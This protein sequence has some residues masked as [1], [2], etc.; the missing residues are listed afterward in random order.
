LIVDVELLEIKRRGNH[1][2]T[3]LTKTGK[4]LCLGL[5]YRKETLMILRDKEEFICPICQETVILKLGDHRIF[6]FAHKQDSNCREFYERETYEHLEGKRQIFQWLTQQNIPCV[7]EYYDRTIQQRPDIMFKYKGQRFALEFQCSSLPDNVFRK[8][9]STYLENGY[10]P[11]WVMSSRHL[12]Q[13]RNDLISLSDFHYSFLRSS[14]NGKLYIPAYCPKKQL[15][16]LVESITPFSIKN[17]FAHLSGLSIQTAELTTILEPK[18]DHCVSQESWIRE[19]EKYIF[20]W[21]LHPKT[22]YRPFLQEVYN[23]GLN[24]FLLPPE[25]G[26]PV[27]HSVLIQTPPFI[28]QTYLFIDVLA[29]K[30]PRELISLRDINSSY[31]KRVNRKQIIL[32]DL[33]QIHNLNPIYAM[34]EYLQVLEKL[35]YLRK[36]GDMIFEVQKKILIPRS[37]REREEAKG[38]FL[39]QNKNI[40]FN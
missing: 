18:N 4:M 1:L 10:T 14:S 3:A 32:R 13:R 6:H 23:Q 39:D 22:E 34:I 29:N 5:N 26:L 24:T 17:S 2:L 11:L 30:N 12:H 28:W 36:K 16:Q 38:I 31:Q 20:N 25:I 7:L 19:M 27:T 9:T 33:P 8:R 15:F 21:A 37:N 35:N 40:I